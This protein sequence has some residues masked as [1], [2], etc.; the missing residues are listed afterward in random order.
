MT[1]SAPRKVAEMALLPSAR[2]VKTRRVSVPLRSVERQIM[3]PTMAPAVPVVAAVIDAP[4]RLT[5]GVPLKQRGAECDGVQSRLSAVSCGCEREQGDRGSCRA[6]SPRR[7]TIRRGRPALRGAAGQRV[8]LDDHVHRLSPDMCQGHLSKSLTAYGRVC[9]R[10]T[11]AGLRAGPRPRR[12]RAPGSCGARGAG[13]SQA[14][15]DSLVR[16]TPDLSGVRT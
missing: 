8:A 10:L 2:A 1:P 14:V 12:I 3:D 7:S 11:P 13:Q 5:C 15:R 6:G 9:R 16:F 4:A